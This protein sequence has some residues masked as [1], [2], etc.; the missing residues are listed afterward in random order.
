VPATQVTDGRIR[1][2]HL[3]CQVGDLNCQ[4]GTSGTNTAHSKKEDDN[5][6]FRVI[7]RA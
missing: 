1:D 5:P 3:N 6:A 7:R 2:I 4:A